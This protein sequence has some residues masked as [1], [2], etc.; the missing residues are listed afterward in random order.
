MLQEASC[1]DG[2]LNVVCRRGLC[3]WKTVRAL[4]RVIGLVAMVSPITC[5]LW[6]GCYP[7]GELPCPEYSMASLPLSTSLFLSLHCLQPP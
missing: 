5:T 1:W 4:G 2:V 3:V 6:W 7:Y